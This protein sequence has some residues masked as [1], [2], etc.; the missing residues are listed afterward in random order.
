MREIFFNYPWVPKS[1]PKYLKQSIF[2]GY[3][4]PESWQHRKNTVLIRRFEDGV[5]AVSQG[6]WWPLKVGNGE[7]IDPILLSPVKDM[8]LPTP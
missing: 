1:G 2:P 4:E 5:G 7:E 6:M 3:S 8:T